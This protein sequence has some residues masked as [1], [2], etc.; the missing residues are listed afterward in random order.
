MLE[1]RLQ[2]E[3]CVETS[4]IEE[5]LQRESWRSTYPSQY[6][7]FSEGKLMGLKSLLPGDTSTLLLAAEVLVL[8]IELSDRCFFSRNFDMTFSLHRVHHPN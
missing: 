8:M 6:L 7:L 1:V 3:V 5:F 2:A 4:C